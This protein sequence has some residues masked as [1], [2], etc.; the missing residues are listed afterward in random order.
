MQLYFVDIKFIRVLVFF[1][2]EFLQKPVQVLD[3]FRCALRVSK[4]NV[5]EPIKILQVFEFQ[6]C[7][8]SQTK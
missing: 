7:K 1:D 2:V 4:R 5:K 8:N 6:L 3:V